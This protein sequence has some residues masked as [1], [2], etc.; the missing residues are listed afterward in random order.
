MLL[1]ADRVT[2][3][4]CGSTEPKLGQPVNVEQDSVLSKVLGT[5]QRSYACTYLK[6]F[7]KI[8][9][10]HNPDSLCPSKAN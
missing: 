8:M 10:T 2:R 7:S 4:Q 6:G 5:N 9:K 1:L 3:A